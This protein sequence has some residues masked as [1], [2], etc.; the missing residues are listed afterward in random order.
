MTYQNF[1]HGH[2]AGYQAL[3]LDMNGTFM[4][5]YDRFGDAD[6]FET[7]RALG[8]NGIDA[9]TVNRMV[10]RLVEEMAD[11][12]HDL[13]FQE[14]FPTVSQTLGRLYPR[15]A[16][17]QLAWIEEVVARH[18]IGHIPEDHIQVLWALSRTHRLGLVTNIWSRKDLWLQAFEA[19]GLADVFE[20]MVFSSDH[21]CI[22]P[23][24]ALFMTAIQEL[25]ISPSDMVFIGDDLRRDM[26]G[27]HNVGLSS[28]WID[29]NPGVDAS[30]EEC[31]PDMRADSLLHLDPAGRFGKESGNGRIKAT[32]T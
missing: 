11:L 2:L 31:L 24:S 6:Y 23:S 22:K 12:Y 5:G 28:L 17:Q 8:A 3:L 30:P 7:Y 18:E 19:R 32:C 20:V 27:A 25:G 4:F 14:D 16:P 26:I 1:N 9:S 10:S 13:S 15:E 21:R 29:M